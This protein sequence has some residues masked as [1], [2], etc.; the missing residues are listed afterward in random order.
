MKTKVMTTSQY[1]DEW[2]KKYLHLFP[3]Y[4]GPPM[5]WHSYSAIVICGQN[6]TNGSDELG[7]NGLKLWRCDTHSQKK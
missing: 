7:S 6:A 3:E 1:W 4:L 2:R 5:C